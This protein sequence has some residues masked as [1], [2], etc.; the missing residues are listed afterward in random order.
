MQLLVQ[1]P[2]QDRCDRPLV[3]AI[4]CIA[5]LRSQLVKIDYQ[6]APPT[7]CE[8]AIWET[9]GAARRWLRCPSGFERQ[10]HGR[11]HPRPPWK[12]PIRAPLLSLFMAA[13]RPSCFFFSQTRSRDLVD[14]DQYSAEHS[15][16][17]TNEQRSNIYTGG[18]NRRTDEGGVI[19]I[20]TERRCRLSPSLE[21]CHVCRT[22]EN[23]VAR[24]SAVEAVTTTSP[25]GHDRQVHRVKQLS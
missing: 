1:S 3:S 9:G 5:R 15:Q 22:A 23:T 18:R 8:L 17:S 13:T 16:T 4:G 25:R 20:C 14:G 24:G 7:P 11:F 19:L 6:S 12:K 2:Y 10:T 21:V